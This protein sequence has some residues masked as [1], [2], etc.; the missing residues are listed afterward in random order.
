MP[1]LNATPLAVL[2][3]P[4]LDRVGREVVLVVLKAT[5][6]VIRGGRV[7]LA[8]EQ[9]PVRTKDVLHDESNPRSSARYPSDVCVEKVGTDVVVVGDAVARQPSMF[10]DVAIRARD[11]TIPIRVNGQ[12]EYFRGILQVAV[13]A[14]VPFESM[15]IAYERAYGGTLDDLSDVEFRNPAGVGFA[16]SAADLVGK[17][18]PQI[19]HPGL[20]HRTAKDAHPPVGCGALLPHWSPRRERAGTFDDV[21]KATRMPL[22]PLDF[23]VRHNSVASPGLSLETP[24]A[25][26]DVISIL[27]MT[28]ELVQFAVPSL[29]LVVRA[30]YD[31]QTEVVSP[32]IDMVLVE[33]ALGRFELTLRRAFSIGRGKN[34]LRELRV[35][36]DE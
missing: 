24:L 16:R 10:V 22:M 25:A 6:D 12:R 9:V 27:G 34:V 26:G 18:A 32:A 17:P 7:V 35:D 14:P 1:V 31:Q 15:P 3:A 8:D 36:V 29:P 28:H 5:F 11:T 19:E 21:W 30:R 20:P 13:S 4:L 23:D 2:D 33:P